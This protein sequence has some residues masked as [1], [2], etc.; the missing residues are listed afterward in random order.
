M[1]IDKGNHATAGESMINLGNVAHPDVSFDE[2]RIKTLDSQDRSLEVVTDSQG[3][4]WLIVGTDSGFEGLSAFYYS[5]ITFLFS[6]VVPPSVGDFSVP[7]GVLAG[8][9]ALGT[10]LVGFG[11]A[12]LVRRRL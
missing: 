6:S 11:T 10:I 7:N 9:A 1:N 2:Y 12:V 4:A 8:A 3:L 5:R